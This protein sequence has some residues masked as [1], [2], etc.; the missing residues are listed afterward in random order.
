MK[1]RIKEIQRAIL[2][3]ENPSPE[4]NIITTYS[5]Y[6]KVRDF[7]H[8]YKYNPAV[9]LALLQLTDLLWKSDKRINRLSLIQSIKR[10]GFKDKTELYPSEIRLLVFQLFRLSFEESSY[11]NPKQIAEIRKLTNSC[12]INLGLTENEETWLTQNAFNADTILNRVLRYPVRSTIISK[13]TRE[14]FYDNRL[15]TRRPE[16]LSWI[17]D[18]VPDYELPKE[19]LEDDFEYLNKSDIKAIK[20]YDDEMEASKIIGTEL[21]D[22]LPKKTSWLWNEN[23]QPPKEL[24]NFSNPELTLSKRFYGIPLDS[25]KEGY[26]VGIPDFKKLSKEFYSTLDRTYSITMLWAVYYSRLDKDL[27]TTLF[28]KYYH[29]ETYF[30]FF[31]LIKK[32][33][34]I[35]LLKWL[36][37]K[38]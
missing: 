20:E 18:E 38:Q 22:F 19:I 16:L 25:S 33:N 34:N 10:Y 9:L 29:D 2:K 17:I 4:D 1:H 12:L 11:L 15:R 30:T 24:I 37:E 31:K 28:K 35:V 8:Y 21:S 7:L 3:I 23:E 26:L 5:D 27:K 32:I 13:W 36:S 6:L 14:H